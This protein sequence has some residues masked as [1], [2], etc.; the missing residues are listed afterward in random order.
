M[1]KKI[2]KPT[3]IITVI[4]ILFIAFI[5]GMIHHGNQYT[6]HKYQLYEMN[7]GVY[8]IYYTTHSSIPAENYEVVTLCCGGNIYTFKGDVFISFTDGEPYARV[9]NYNM[10]NADDIYIYIPQGTIIYNPSVNISR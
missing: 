6:E 8:A 10:V 3:V 4:C 9:K 5:G 7:D 1:F 2:D